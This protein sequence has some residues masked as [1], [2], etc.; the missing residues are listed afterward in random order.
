MAINQQQ[1][2]A[3]FLKARQ[4]RQVSEVLTKIQALPTKQREL[5][6]KQNADLFSSAFDHFIDDSNQV[7]N[8]VELDDEALNLSRDIIQGLKDSL[9]AVGKIFYREQ[10]LKA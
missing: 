8:H 9:S 10:E 3:L 5:W 7:L 4:I 6:M 1:K 2:F